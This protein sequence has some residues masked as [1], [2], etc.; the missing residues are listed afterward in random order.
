MLVLDTGTQQEWQA[1]GKRER[2]AAARQQALEQEIR[3]SVVSVNLEDGWDCSSFAQRVGSPLATSEVVRRLKLCNPNLIF[4]RSIQFPELTGLYYEVSER[5]PAGTWTKRKI[6]LFLMASTE[7]MPEKE[8][9]HVRTK[10][11]PSADVIAATGGQPVDRDAVK[12]DEIPEPYDYTRGW[13]TV[14][15]RLLRAK[16]ITKYH[17][18]KYFPERSENSKN[19]YNHMKVEV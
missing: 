17:V 18:D 1:A 11:V 7:I 19:W 13:S 3:S 4:E 15:I 16:F 12:W 8:I 5:T 10:R 14:L 6:H 9:V 2:S